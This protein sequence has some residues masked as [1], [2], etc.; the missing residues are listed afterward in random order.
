[1]T[2]AQDV[3]RYAD[4]ILAMIKEDQDS[5]QVPRDVLT[6]DEV[7]ASVDT[8]DY[9]RQAQLPSG[10]AEAASLRDAV[11]D[12]VSHRLTGSQAG[13][14]NVTWTGPGGRSVDIGRTIGYPTR[15]EADAVGKR[16][17]TDHGGAYRVHG[18]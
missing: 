1:M 6:W 16:Y 5:G 14:W 10:T 15:E 18:S 4:A 8:G 12:E 2:D 3:Q 9:W 7:D 13:P 11:T 17:L